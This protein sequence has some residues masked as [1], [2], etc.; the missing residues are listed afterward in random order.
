M[1]KQLL[2]VVAAL[3]VQ[4]TLPV[5]G[6]ITALVMGDNTVKTVSSVAELP[7]HTMGH[8][9]TG[10]TYRIR[11][12][13]GNRVEAYEI[14]GKTRAS[15]DDV[16]VQCKGCKTD[17]KTDGTCG[18][19]RHAACVTK[20]NTEGKYLM[21]QGNKHMRRVHVKNAEVKAKKSTKNMNN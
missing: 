9:T 13:E 7:D 11:C 12:C 1:K 18:N 2:F 6:A 21:K 19:K 16:M 4:S 17:K 5:S 15:S 10:Q 3:G 8:I 14:D 20:F